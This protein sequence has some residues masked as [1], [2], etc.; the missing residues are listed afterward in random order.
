[1]RG[2]GMVASRCMVSVVTWLCVLL[3]GDVWAAPAA[4]YKPEGE[5]RWAFLVI[6][7]AEWDR[8]TGGGAG[9]DVD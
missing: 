7:L 2:R 3:A 9:A 8:A 1:M 5:M 6:H 4:A